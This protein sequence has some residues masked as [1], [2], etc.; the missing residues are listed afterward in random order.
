[1]E[2]FY[3]RCKQILEEILLP[4]G[5]VLGA[6]SSA[7]LGRSVGFAKGELQV[8]W[9]YDLRE[10][11]L[12]LKMEQERKTVDIE[13]FYGVEQLRSDFLVGLEGMLNAQGLSIAEHNK[14]LAMDD[15]ASLQADKSQ[16]NF[17]SNLFGRISRK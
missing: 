9:L 8:L 6:E 10:Q 17:L 16:P 2:M 7:G 5:F 11:R 15:L 1:M 3:Y 13:S 14:R 12:V 4:Q